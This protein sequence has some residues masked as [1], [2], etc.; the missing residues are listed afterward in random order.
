[1]PTAP[2]VETLQE[3]ADVEREQEEGEEH[4]D[5]SDELSEDHADGE[6]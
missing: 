2:A 1:M 3:S 6:L 5:A 4:V